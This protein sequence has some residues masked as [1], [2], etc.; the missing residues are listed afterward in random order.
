M[1]PLEAPLYG[2]WSLPSFPNEIEIDGK[3]FHKAIRKQPYVGVIEQYRE[4]VP[5][6]SM[7]LVVLEDGQWMIDHVDAYN[8]DMGYPFRH[9]MI[10]HP[11]GKVFL[12]TGAGLISMGIAVKRGMTSKKEEDGKL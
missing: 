7:H 10:D 3:V 8:P 6:D 5:R 1:V 12:F 2:D 11:I 9:F 4:A